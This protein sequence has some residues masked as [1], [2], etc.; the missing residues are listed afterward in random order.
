MSIK[1][2]YFF[3]I[4]STRALQLEIRLEDLSFKIQSLQDSHLAESQS[5]RASQQD[6][7]NMLFAKLHA[8]QQIADSTQCALSSRDLD[9]GFTVSKDL[10]PRG[11]EK[12]KD[13][14]PNVHNT[15]L[16]NDTVLS[17]ENQ[18]PAVIGLS[19]RQLAI[20]VC[21][22]SCCCQCHRRR[23]WRS[24]QLLD[25]VLGAL[26]IGY[27]RTPTATLACDLTSCSGTQRSHLTVLYVFPQWFLQS[28][29]SVAMVYT[30]G[31]G[32][33]VSIRTVRIR[34]QGEQVFFYAERGYL[35][36]VQA[37]FRRGE[38]SPFDIEAG[39][40]ESLLRVRTMLL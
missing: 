31:R 27:S 5:T 1:L 19:V 18:T 16:S 37:L 39:T 7:L 26:F 17:P 23:H 14:M 33:E 28:I 13:S 3:S 22:Q 25:Q 40:H 10:V 20:P 35:T 12:G 38:A 6:M 8:L 4:S 9:L 30:K 34:R 32:L 2:I 24:P 11:S 29:L 36:K 15:Q 21:Q